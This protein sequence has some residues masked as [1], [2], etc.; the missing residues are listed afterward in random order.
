[1]AVSIGDLIATL[2]LD[3]KF[4][5]DIKTAEKDLTDFDEAWAGLRTGVGAAVAAVT[6]VSAAVI[7]LGMRGA[8]VADMAETF[9]EL[10]AR[11]G[12]T[13]GALNVISDALDGTVNDFDIM[14]NTNTALSLGLKLTEDQFKSTAEGARLLADR[15]GRTA[16]DA[17]QTL[18]MA[19]ATGRDRQ[20]RFLGLTVDTEAAVKKMEL[21]LGKSSGELTKAQTTQAK[22]EAILAALNKQLEQSGR[23][24]LDFGDR[25][26][27]VTTLMANLSD[28]TALT[29]QNVFMEFDKQL[30]SSSGFLDDFGISVGNLRE[31]W[32][33]SLNTIANGLVNLVAIV[34]DRIT[35]AVAIITTFGTETAA[36]AGQL[37]DALTFKTDPATALKNIGAVGSGAMKALSGSILDLTKVQFTWNDYTKVGTKLVKE[38]PPPVDKLTDSLKKQEETMKRLVEAMKAHFDAAT[39]TR[40]AQEELLAILGPGS[41]DAT[42]QMGRLADATDR[43]GGVTALT[44]AQLISLV[45]QLEA[46]IALGGQNEEGFTK[47]AEAMNEAGNRGVYLNAQLGILAGKPPKI[48]E[49][50]K[51]VT[52]S[53][54]D[55]QNALEGVIL[56]ADMLGGPFEDL[57]QIISTVGDVF[58]RLKDEI[59]AVNENQALT[60]TQKDAEKLK[61]TILAVATAAGILGAALSKSA[62]PAVAKFGGALQGAAAGAKLGTAILPGWGTAIGGLVGGIFGFINAGKKLR[63][64]MDDIKTKFLDS[65][66]GMDSLKQHALEAGIGIETIF[67]AKSK[68]TL[69]AAIDEVQKKLD[70]WDEA[71]TKLQAAIEKYGITVAELGP[72]W[73][74]Q[75]M[76]KKALDLIES[77]KLLAAAGVEV[78]TLIEKMGPDML[79]FV[80]EAVAAGTTIPLA[81]KPMIDA[82]WQAGKLLHEDGTAF[83][84]AEYKAL[85]FGASTSQMFMT[86]LDKIDQLVNAL[87]GIPDKDVNVNVHTRYPN[88]KPPSGDSDVP[89]ADQEDP[90]NGYP[91]AMASGGIVTR[92]TLA[93]IGEAG[94]EAIVPLSEWVAQG[95]NISNEIRSLRAEMGR[96]EETIHVPLIVDSKVLA[97]VL[98]RRNRAGLFKIIPSKG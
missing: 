7:A 43:L 12:N 66:G 62:N 69:L 14:H 54:F 98:V 6:A 78:T 58:S 15:T 39:K 60:D 96:R 22:S 11:I 55:W 72:K 3:N 2:E 61:L 64:E 89:P 25:V 48:D 84:E 21:A 18:M 97:D 88:G 8:D 37:W 36:T 92:P 33:F 73:A 38:T 31:T 13:A 41:Q 27:Q 81:M 86:L 68:N 79:A 46:Q 29:T 40:T 49:V 23:V 19:M 20:L 35:L 42:I 93:Y 87:L 45:K 1:M 71:N 28:I 53:T 80:D 34:V 77:W 76:D 9:N 59:K 10:Q 82:M 44:D 70:T 26:A 65:V 90:P 4:S 32:A 30:V 63:K 74:Q 24:A 67:A 75:A 17:F 91:P 47:M 56:L 52:K 16:S 94:P 85:S 50:V 51:Q 57:A 5:K 83:T 95:E